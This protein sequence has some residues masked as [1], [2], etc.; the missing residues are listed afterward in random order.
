MHADGLFGIDRVCLTRTTGIDAERAHS[1][2]RCGS[3]GTR[4]RARLRGSGGEGAGAVKAGVA[5][6]RSKGS[7][8]GPEHSSRIPSAGPGG[9]LTLGRPGGLGSDVRQ[10]R[11][12]TRG[13][14]EA[15]GLGD[16][17]VPFAK[18]LRLCRV[19]RVGEPEGCH[20]AALGVPRQGGRRRK[21]WQAR[22]WRVHRRAL[23]LRL[24]RSRQRG[25][26]GIALGPAQRPCNRGGPGFRRERPGRHDGTRL[27]SG[28]CATL[29]RRGRA[30]GV[31]GAL[32]FASHVRAHRPH[33]GV[34]ERRST[35]GR[36]LR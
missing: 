34:L 21:R 9:L 14:L 3:A 16:C 25:G 19:E 2:S 36:C 17:F 26:G 1:P 29:A 13:L 27:A 4:H 8:D 12:S 24:A 31:P 6:E 5:A 7:L 18:P 10:L 32:P 20:Q 30:A 35:V 28:T 23:A 22:E 11:R 33:V 15:L